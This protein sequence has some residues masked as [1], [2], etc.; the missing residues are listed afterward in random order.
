MSVITGRSRTRLRA[1]GAQLTMVIL[2]KQQ[3]KLIK[4][5]VTPLWF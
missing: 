1:A 4:I 5:R 2:N 3:I